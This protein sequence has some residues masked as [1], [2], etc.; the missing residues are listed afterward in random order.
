[1]DFLSYS[2]DMSRQ[3]PPR[4]PNQI[5]AQ[6]LHDA[7]RAKG[8]T[9]EKAAAELEPYIG[10]RWSKTVWSNAERSADSGPPRQFT[11]DDI[12]AL[13]RCFDVPV[14]Y[15]FLPSDFSPAPVATSDH[16]DG[17]K[18]AE[19]LER[20]V[21]DTSL[22][23]RRVEA[24]IGYIPSDELTEAQ[25]QLQEQ[26]QHNEIVIMQRV[27]GDL[28]Y[29]RRRMAYAAEMFARVERGVWGRHISSD[30]DELPNIPGY[31]EEGYLD[32]DVKKSGVEYKSHP[33]FEPDDTDRRIAAYFENEDQGGSDTPSHVR[34]ITHM[35]N[36]MYQCSAEEQVA[37]GLREEHTFPLTNDEHNE[38]YLQRRRS[39]EERMIAGEI[40]NAMSLPWNPKTKKWSWDLARIE[41]GT[42]PAEDDE[43][44]LPR[45]GYE[46]F[47][48]DERA[49]AD[50][51]A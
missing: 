9:Q 49:G 47:L 16:P 30:D 29:W 36:V 8:W 43:G 14:L 25:R 21:G 11:A 10:T 1:M 48:N 32:E 12:V 51:S 31:D 18:P 6:N 19:Y 46:R 7:R 44:E 41:A 4:T 39:E 24:A 37:A 28:R 35:A 23:L 22:L 38:E 34:I 5:V 20:V 2:A 27:F 3:D 40:A 50:D 26:A 45:P 13:A 17:M 15:F 33:E 42:Q